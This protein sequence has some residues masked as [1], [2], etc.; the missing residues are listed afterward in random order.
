MVRTLGD[1]YPPVYGTT[2]TSFVG[3]TGLSSMSAGLLSAALLLTVLSGA[4]VARLR[5]P[6]RPSK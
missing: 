2:S 1:Y 4:I 6:P 5:R 3:I